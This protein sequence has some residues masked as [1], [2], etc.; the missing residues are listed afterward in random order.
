[1]NKKK[2]KKKASA[3]K[4]SC[5]SGIVSRV[6]EVLV[7]ISPEEAYET[8]SQIEDK[9]KLKDD[10]SLSKEQL[11]SL[12]PGFQKLVRKKYK[13]TAKLPRY[14]MAKVKTVKAIIALVCAAAD[15][16]YGK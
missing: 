13:P 1:M 15:F 16:T 4:K 2:T 9:L 7:F 10:L 5:P 12:A 6:K 3:T 8:P 11:R 14:K